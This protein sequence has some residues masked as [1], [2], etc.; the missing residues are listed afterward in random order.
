MR[1]RLWHLGIWLACCLVAAVIVGRAHYTADL[2]AFLPDTPTPAQQMLVEQLREGPASRL[3][4][5]AVEGADAP[6]RAALSSA[7]TER[8]RAD[9]RFRSVNNGESGTSSADQQ[10]VFGH[11]YLL[12]TRIEPAYFEIAGLR[13]T[14]QES[15]E[16]LGSPLGLLAK[17]LYTRDPTGETLQVISQLLRPTQPRSADGVWVSQDGLRALLVA[18][19][20]AGGADTDGQQQAIDAVRTAFA[21]VQAAQP[22]RGPQPTLRLTGPAV[23][24]VDAR[25]MIQHEAV[26][27]SI[28]SSLLIAT[29]L[30]LIYRSARA[31]L[32]GMLPVASGALAG[33]AAVSLG[34]S[35]VHGVTLG[36]GVTLI[37]ESV[38]YSVYLFIQG[39]RQAGAG[40][41]HAQWTRT[42]WPTIR[43]GMLTSVCGFASLLP[44][45]FPGL[46][47]LGLYSIAGLVAAALVTRFVMPLLLPAALSIGEVAPL[48]RAFLGITHRLGRVRQ[49]LWLIPLIAAAVLVADRDHLWNRELSALSPVAKSAQEFDSR[50]RAD[51]GAADV[52]TLVV[53]SAADP[54]K[55]LEAADT[56]TGALGPLVASGAIAGFDSPTHYLPA[57]S[58]QRR[59]Q[60]SLPAAAALRAAFATAIRTLPLNPDRF[61][62]F[63]ADVEAARHAPPVNR[64]DM[65]G[66]SIASGADAL[67]IRHGSRWSALVPLEAAHSGAGAYHIDV[68]LVTRTVGSLSTPGAEVVVLDLKRESDSL[69]SGYLSEA[70][71]LSLAG[72]AAILLLL[73]ATLR[74]AARIVRVLAPLLLAVL[75][76]MT[77][78]ALAGHAM[79]I[80][81]LVGLL[82][83]VAIGSNYSLFFDREAV[84]HDAATTARTVASLLVANLTTVLGFGVLA[85][86]SVPVLSAV[87]S[88]VAPGAFLALVFAAILA[89]PGSR[90]QT[91]SSA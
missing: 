90:L 30:L 87:G 36:F 76:V 44:S 14:L 7:L 24:A 28:L 39:Q 68:G 72:L 66:T 49:A 64:R 35:V 37:G 51:L 19:T 86:S 31:L 45:S 78:F 27:L 89:P 23:F 84:E 18:E 9:R 26:R 12:S 21:A 22:T 15:V 69:Y 5:G 62:E 59:R 88:T 38:D 80:L 79:T 42:F 10:F 55:A 65:E 75:A 57:V 70:V 85:A 1:A 91:A 43:L 6:A 29:F 83:I 52:R 47:Q 20:V 46:A 53:V 8:L 63:F 33:V 4:L 58:V 60:A 48:G 2:S 32:L 82:L 56:V 73:A 17:D 71:R 40:R 81:H 54:E 74:S 61:E 34:F 3:I 25:A 67:L 16:L 11:R 13:A 41:D 50:M 77:T